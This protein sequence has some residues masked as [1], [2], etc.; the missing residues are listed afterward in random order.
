MCANI[1]LVLPN[2]LGD[3]IMAAPVL[4]GLKHSF[5]GCRASFLVED[6]FEGG[7]TGN[8]FCDEIVRFPRRSLRDALHSKDWHA[9]LLQVRDAVSQISNS[10]FSR[11]VNLSQAEYV[12]HLV[13]LV[14][15]G[16]YAGR[17]FLAEGNH[18]VPDPW[19][20]YLYAIPFARRQNA[21]HATDIY[22]R[23][24]G[25]GRTEAR[26]VHLGDNERARA[27]DFLT[28]LGVDLSNRRIVVFQ[29]G[30]AIPAKRWPENSFVRLGIMLRDRGWH[31]VVS[32]A[33][34]ESE[35]AL[36]I[37]KGIGEGCFCTAGATSFREA[38]AN[39][40]WARACVSGDTALMHAAAGIGVQVFALF[41][42]TNPVE[43]GPYGDGHWAFSAH[44][45]DRPC[46]C[47]ECKSMLCMKAI[48]PE[49]VCN[50]IVSQS[51]GDR[52]RCDVYR[53]SI[54]S[55][56]DFALLPAHHAAHG[57]WDPAGAAC[58]RRLLDPACGM[59]NLDRQEVQI[60]IEQS[61]EFTA[62]LAAIQRHLADY[63]DTGDR[64]SIEAHE[65][66]K[67]TLPAD[68]S[69]AAFWTAILNLRLN[70]I[71]VLD[72]VAAVQAS[73]AACART[74]TEIADVVAAAREGR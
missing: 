33:G 13:S 9:G 50:C 16:E 5:A 43:T 47:S 69:L 14:A 58:T 66:I 72:P 10:G 26:A 19:S 36:R 31:I 23:I 49:T 52:P 15:A 20:Q 37:Q 28:Q 24:A 6:G 60:C 27:R 32:G 11:V 38:I 40:S 25:A 65:A 1:L 7:L 46:F 2:N 35:T 3:V 59:E 48:L 74:R 45:A 73:L 56:G 39:L 62:A 44:C 42:A 21:F 51:P 22:R 55:G 12:S 70:S 68:G 71:P 67:A 18:A 61:R 29:P 8:P 64:K 41:G 57:Y 30:A 4:S 54:N 53:T 17:R 34:A 63:L